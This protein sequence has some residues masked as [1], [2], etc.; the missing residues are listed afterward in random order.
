MPVTVTMTELE[1]AA[2]AGISRTFYANVITAARPAARRGSYV[3]ISVF[4]ALDFIQ[5]V[6]P[7]PARASVSRKWLCQ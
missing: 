7:G 1:K 2:E 6:L 4:R 5:V 3:H